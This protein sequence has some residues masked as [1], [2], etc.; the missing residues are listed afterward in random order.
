MSVLGY[1]PLLKPTVATGVTFDPLSLGTGT[2]L[3]GGNLTASKAS[4]A[5]GVAR[6]TVGKSTGKWYAEFS[7]DSGTLGSHVIGLVTAAND[8]NQ[9]LGDTVESW[10]YFGSV[11][12]SGYKRHF[13]GAFTLYGTTYTTGDIMGIALDMTGGQ[14]TVYKNNTSQGVMFTS[15]TGTLYMAVHGYAAL[16]AVITAKF[17]QSSWT[18]SAPSG[19]VELTP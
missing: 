10:A 11:A 9:Q 16:A 2:T 14:V 18:Y 8:P 5:N 7:I 15:L 1:T 4:G 19:F 12:G 17:A 6:C 3:S 13:P